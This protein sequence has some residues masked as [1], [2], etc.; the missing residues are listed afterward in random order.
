VERLVRREVIHQQQAVAMAATLAP[1]L[2][3]LVA[4]LILMA[5]PVAT[6]A[7]VEPSVT[8]VIHRGLPF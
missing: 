2:V 6:G 4:L 3:A 8:Q 1:E 5:V 7:E